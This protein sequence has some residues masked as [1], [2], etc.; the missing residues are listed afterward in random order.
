MTGRALASR[1]KDGSLQTL[2]VSLTVVMV[3]TTVAIIV[4]RDLLSHPALAD[5]APNRPVE[6]YTLK[7]RPHLLVDD[8]LIA[9]SEGVERKVIPPERSLDGPV[10][11]STL[12]HQNWQPFLTVLY[13]PAAPPRK[14][15]RMWYN[16]DVVDDP[17]DGAFSGKTAYLDSSDGIHWPGPYE[18]LDS[19]T[20][21]GRAR[22]GASVVDDGPRHLP[23][24]ERYKILYF[25]AGQRVGPRVAFSPD[26]LTWTM[27]DGGNPVLTNRDD[28]WSAA[29]DPIRRRYFLIGKSYGPY[30][31]TNA[32]GK[33]IT[34]NIRRYFTSFSQDF[35]TWSEPRIVFSPDDRDSGITQWYGAAGFMVR[36]DLILG[37]LRVLRDDLSPQGVPPEAV[38]S[39]VSG[40]AGLGGAGPGMGS[41]MGYTVLAWTRDGENWHRDRHSDPYFEPDPAVGAWDHAMAWVGSSVAVGDDVYLYYAGYRWGHKY[42]HSV[43]RQLGLVKVRRDRFVARQAGEQGGTITTR[44][45]VLDLASLTLNVDAQGGEVRA[46]VSDAAGRPIPGFTFAECRPIIADSLAAPVEWQRPLSALRGQTV[47]LEFSL[48]NA[49]LFAFD[50]QR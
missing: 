2:R 39:N 28:I 11:T 26:G 40:K 4:P 48:K 16:A 30:T 22:F 19:L 24:D 14:P 49:R 8:F 3:L 21:D 10:V 18:R 37:F 44:P 31:W 15:F 23:P 25:D 12:E 50:G 1:A 9:E 38:A 13:D 45:V 5:E 6:A 17:T 35:R 41:G 36:G 34:A 42:R 47:R 7:A 27:H 20:V 33:K 29:F 43:D 46:Q 32:E